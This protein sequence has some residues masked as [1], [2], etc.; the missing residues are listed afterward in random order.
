MIVRH[1]SNNAN[2]P[3]SSTGDSRRVRQARFAVPHASRALSKTTPASQIQKLTASQPTDD[4]RP[5]VS[6]NACAGAT[7]HS[8]E[9][10]PSWFAPAGVQPLTGSLPGSSPIAFDPETG[11][12]TYA[13]ASPGAMGSGAA[14][15]DGARRP[16]RLNRLQPLE[17]VTGRSKRT[18]TNSQRADRQAGLSRWPVKTCASNTNSTRID[19]CHEARHNVVTTTSID[20]MDGMS[21]S[22]LFEYSLQFVQVLRGEALA[23]CKMDQ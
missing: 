18:T 2:A 4:R 12:I 17:G 23:P 10:N 3:G 5:A 21:A 6:C 7:G 11:T 16:V 15:R 20:S 8:R 13:T 19:D 22:F 14:E 9:I 1:S